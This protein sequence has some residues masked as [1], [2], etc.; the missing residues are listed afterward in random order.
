MTD[1]TAVDVLLRHGFVRCD[2]PACNCG[3]WHPKYGLPERLEEIRIALD[4]A[5][6]PLTNDNGHLVLRALE[7]LI[8]ERNK[9][10]WLDDCIKKSGITARYEKV[11]L[12]VIH[13]TFDRELDVCETK[14]Q[15]AHAEIA[16]LTACLHRAA[17]TCDRIADKWRAAWAPSRYNDGGY[18]AATECAE[19]LRE[20]REDAMT[21][22]TKPA[23]TGRLRAHSAQEA[24]IE[25]LKA[26]E[27][28]T[29]ANLGRWSKDA[30][31]EVARLN[32]EIERLKAAVRN[33]FD[34]LS[35]MDGLDGS[36]RATDEQRQSGD[37][38]LDAAEAALRSLVK[39]GTILRVPQAL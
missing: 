36:H 32:G 5:G 20:T 26:D 14:L 29:Q 13:G 7:A 4:D 27:D 34:A 18:D 23:L 22:D 33:Y 30:R 3:S 21:E 28:R 25:L 9:H 11:M 1:D 19:A 39:S 24:E 37:D 6:H 15:E 12:S 8:A 16:R 38:E 2:I 31:L 35:V 17:A 10:K